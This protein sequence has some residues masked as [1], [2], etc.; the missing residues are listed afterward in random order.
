[1][2]FLYLVP[3]GMNEPEQPT[4]GS[5]AGRYGPMESSPARP[6]YWANQVDAWEDTTNRD[7]TLRRW[8]VDLQNDFRARLNWRVKP[9]GQANHPPVAIV[10]G[11]LERRVS[12]ETIV[13]LSAVG[14]R[15][16]DRNRL[17]CQWIF[18][19]EA[20]TYKGP[21]TIRNA[22]SRTASFL[23]PRVT[24][25]E[26]IHIILRVTGTGEPPLSRYRRV[27]VRVD[28]GSQ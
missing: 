12:P 24:S 16:P 20:R 15:D 18:Y 23:A 11:L 7:N 14:S 1:M 9:F 25:S 13:T 4:W 8:A 19:Q 17:A 26:A 5:W 10:Q 3:T 6:Y 21:L 28:P 2:T 22:G 27:I